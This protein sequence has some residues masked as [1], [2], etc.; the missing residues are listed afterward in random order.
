M[1]IITL[2][3]NNYEKINQFHPIFSSYNYDNIF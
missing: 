2:I 1:I 3:Q